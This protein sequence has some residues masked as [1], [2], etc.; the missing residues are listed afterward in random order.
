[1]DMAAT[2]NWAFGFRQLPIHLRY[3]LDCN[4]YAKPNI[5][6]IQLFLLGFYD[7]QSPKKRQTPKRQTE[8][9]QGFSAR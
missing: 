4:A 2:L 3:K 9:R 8:K 7:H 6:S 5:F 1:M